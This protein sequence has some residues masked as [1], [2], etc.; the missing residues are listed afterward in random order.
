MD[1]VRAVDIPSLDRLLH[2]PALVAV[3]ERH[4]R[5]AVIAALRAELGQLR[6][7]ALTRTARPE[8]FATATVALAVSDRLAR[9]AQPR[10]RPV[11]N[12]SGTVLHTHLGRAVL[13]DEAVAAV[14]TALKH[15][16]NLELDLATGRRGERD[17]IV[18]ARLCELTGAQAATVVNNDAAAVLLILSALAGRREVIV[19]RGEL[20]EIGGS[21][22]LP[23]IMRAAGVKLREVGTTNRTHR[24]D[25]EDAIGPRTALMLKVHT[26]NYVIQGFT[27]SVETHELASLARA[28]ALP[29]VADLGS[30]ALVDFSQWGLPPE[31][32]VRAT[33]AAGADL[34]AFSGDKLL[35]GPQAGLIVGRAELIHKLRAH[36]LK[37]AL[38]V[39]KP[40]LAALEAVLMLYRS[41]ESLPQRLTLLHLLTRSREN[42]RQQTERV[43]PRVR[44]ALCGSFEVAGAAMMSQIGSGAL[45]LEELASYGLV[46]AARTSA[47]GS[48]NALQKR[49][50]A[51]E[52]P[53][54]G[55]AA[56]GKLW[57]DLRCLAAADEE[58][59]AA[60]WS[61]VNA[62][63]GD[64]AHESTS[65]RAC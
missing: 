63:Q 2:E 47:R 26:S 53:V 12:L 8:A 43:L 23:D 42:I 31:V 3:L 9:E 40:I 24:S 11:F 58:A 52:R 62:A 6:D 16:V 56:E 41:P 28:H 19:S 36:P 54:I 50:R 34:V 61:A 48:V 15:P 44:A 29:L 57:L 5:T 30:G 45:P 10:L 4:G 25:Y 37:R 49:L 27:A 17:A 32:T 7:A 64:G 60:Q 46:I 18:E 55:R 22:R 14:V 38:R 33:V 13:P 35:G 1:A 21:F 20:V 65:G 39:G 51:L 59:F